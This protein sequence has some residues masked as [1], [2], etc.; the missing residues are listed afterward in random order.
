M[1]MVPL[2]DGPVFELGNSVE[3]DISLN[4]V[5]VSATIVNESNLSIHR[6]MVGLALLV[7]NSDLLRSQKKQFLSKLSFWLN[8]SC[9]YI[10]LQTVS[11]TV[12]CG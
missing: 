12:Q 2:W 6:Q 11:L 7:S 5:N 4:D 1:G 10:A 8:N 3:I 9:V